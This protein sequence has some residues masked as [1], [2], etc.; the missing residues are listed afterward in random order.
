NVVLHRDWVGATQAM[1]RTTSLMVL[2]GLGWAWTGSPIGAY[3]LLGASVM[4][5][6]FS[7]FENPAL[8]MT[9]IFWWQIVGAAA[10]LICQLVLWPM[11]ANEL[12]MLLMM[13]PLIL[14]GVVPFAH[15]RLSS[16]SMDYFM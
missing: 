14:L 3:V 16:G 5:T 4:V 9:H 13:V 2:L 6:L 8:I 11:A 1:Y 7:T 15:R 10:N 12:Q